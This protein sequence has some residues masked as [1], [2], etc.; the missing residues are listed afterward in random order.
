[1][2]CGFSFTHIVPYVVGKRV[3]NA[4]KRMDVGGKLLTNHLKEIG[5]NEDCCYVAQDWDNNTIA[6]DYVLPDFTS[7][8]RGVMKSQEESTVRPGEGEQIIRMNNE[9]FMVPEVLFRPSDIG[10]C[11]MGLSE[12]VVEAVTSC[13]SAAQLWLYRNII[14]TGNSV[15]FSGFRERL[16]AEV[17]SLA[18]GE[19]EV[20]VREVTEDPL[21]A[22]CRG[23]ASLA[24]DMEFRNLVVTKEEYIKT[25]FSACQK[26]FYL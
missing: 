26:K 12:A 17:C 15:K 13:D 14:L 8:R 6:R 23:G 3:R 16:E 21:T 4:V 22:T 19:M 7:I 9:R 1:M 10:I 2:D 18:P 11:Q 20:R 24:S 5:A 25:G